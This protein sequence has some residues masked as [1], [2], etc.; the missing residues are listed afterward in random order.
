[1]ILI[2]LT[3][4]CLLIWVAIYKPMWGGWIAIAIF[5]I[6]HFTTPSRPKRWTGEDRRYHDDLNETS[7]DETDEEYERRIKADDPDA[8]DDL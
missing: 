2:R 1:M 6:W 8:F 3:V 5:L 7:D 4:L